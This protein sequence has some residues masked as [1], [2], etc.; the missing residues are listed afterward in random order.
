MSIS[1]N[2]IIVITRCK[3]K[4]QSCLQ[5]LLVIEHPIHAHRAMHDHTHTP[6]HNTPTH[7][8]NVCASP[9]WRRPTA[10]QG[11]RPSGSNTNQ[12]LAL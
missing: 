11:P 3:A 5:P 10:V 7:I 1:L 12:V 9:E 4:S 6:Q 2:T 8:N